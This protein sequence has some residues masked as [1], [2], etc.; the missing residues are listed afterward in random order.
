MKQH[1]IGREF[2]LEGKGL[3][4]GMQIPLHA[5]PAEAGSGIV[6]RRVDLGE[7]IKASAEYVKIQRKHCGDTYSQQRKIGVQPNQIENGV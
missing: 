1:T 3:H 5:K 2:S 4:T 6:I 7:E